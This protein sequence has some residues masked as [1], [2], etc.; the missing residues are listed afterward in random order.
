MTDKNPLVK[1]VLS[2]ASIILA[3]WMLSIASVSAN[4]RPASPPPPPKPLNTNSTNSTTTSPPATTLTEPAKDS[5]VEPFTDANSSSPVNPNPSPSSAATPVTPVT[6]AASTSPQPE[7]AVSDRPLSSEAVQAETEATGTTEEQRLENLIQTQV[8]RA[9][10]RRN[11]FFYALFGAI[12]IMLGGTWVFLWLLRQNLTKIVIGELQQ[13]ISGQLK[14]EI[15]EQ[16]KAEISAEFVETLAQ[17]KN[18]SA[19][20]IAQ[21]QPK[22]IDNSTQINELISMAVAT[23]N[24]LQ[25]TRSALEESRKLHD[26]INQPIQE[27]FGIY[28]KQATEL[29]QQGEYEEA[30]EMYDKTLQTNPDFYEAWLGRGIAF[31][32]LKQYETAIGCYNKALQLNSDHPEPWYEKA[33]CYAIKQDVDLVID[34]LQRAIKANPNMRKIALQDPDFEIIFDHEILNQST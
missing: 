31:A 9:L 16:I 28:F 22:S 7:P 30:I 27:I 20:A 32:R 24:L 1:T 25:E 6:P 2:P 29:L 3:T 14:A 15:G 4:P 8:D 10:G 23:N 5:T 13:K 19:L 33:R 18:N 11:S 12:L 26:R 21:P 17:Q 34:N